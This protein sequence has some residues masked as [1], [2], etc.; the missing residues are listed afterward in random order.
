MCGIQYPVGLWVKGSYAQSFLGSPI[1][2]SLGYLDPVSPTCMP[3]C[4]CGGQPAMQRL[5]QGPPA[6]LLCVSII[7][8]AHMEGECPTDLHVVIINEFLEEVGS[9]HISP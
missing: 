9:L 6:G 1:P 8:Q 4:M 3:W 2:F 5:D 7:I